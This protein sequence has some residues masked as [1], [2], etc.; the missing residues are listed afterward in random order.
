MIEERLHSDSDSFPVFS[1]RNFYKLIHWDFIEVNFPKEDEIDLKSF[2]ANLNLI[3][4][5]LPRIFLLL[6]LWFCL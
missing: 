2:Q 6:L 4:N 5:N 1:N 3:K